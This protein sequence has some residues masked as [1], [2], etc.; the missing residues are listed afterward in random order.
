MLNADLCLCF[1]LCPI[2]IVKFLS[3]WMCS[4]GVVRSKENQAAWLGSPMQSGVWWGAL[5][6]LPISCCSC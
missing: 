4:L 1:L 2:P 6:R 3:L 5:G